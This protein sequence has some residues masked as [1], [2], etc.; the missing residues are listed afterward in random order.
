[1]MTPNNPRTSPVDVGEFIRIPTGRTEGMVVAVR[2]A[3]FGSADA[4]EVLLK[5]RPDDPMP[6]WYRLEP[7]DYEVL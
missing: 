2:D 6:R 4:V 7:N 5:V 1:M 3:R